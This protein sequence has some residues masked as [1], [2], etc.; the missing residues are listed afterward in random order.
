ML[1]Q[2]GLDIDGEKQQ[3]FLVANCLSDDE[4]HRNYWALYCT[5]C[6]S[7]TVDVQTVPCC[8]SRQRQKKKQNRHRR[9]QDVEDPRN[10]GFMGEVLYFAQE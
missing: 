7:L 2:L 1:E 5:I 4:D 6:T 9:S 3:V 8:D 10:S